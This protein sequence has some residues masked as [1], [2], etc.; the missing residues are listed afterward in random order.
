[1]YDKNKLTAAYPSRDMRGKTLRVTYLKTG[2]SVDVVVND[3]GP[4]ISGRVIDLSM[5]AARAIGL[6]ADGVGRVRVEVLQ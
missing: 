6:M 3:Y 2:R 4:H 1:M 5:A